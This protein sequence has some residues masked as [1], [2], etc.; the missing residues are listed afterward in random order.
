MLASGPLADLLFE[1]AMREPNSALAK[2]FGWLTGTGPGAG[3]A[4]IMLIS[5][6]LI[7]VIAIVTFLTPRVRNVETIL[8]DFDKIKSPEE[9]PVS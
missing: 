3:M 7:V 2:L 8:P 4:L 9:A 6:A 5:G 1:P